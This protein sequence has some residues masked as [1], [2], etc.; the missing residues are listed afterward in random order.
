[1]QEVAILN[2]PFFNWVLLPFLIFI[3]RIIDVSI[4]T[5][6]LMLMARGRKIMA[7]ILGFFEVFIWI[8]AVRQI[9]NNLNNMA[10]YI[11]FP[12]GF[13]VGNYVGMI[14]EEKLAMG[15]VVIRIITKKEGTGLFNILK[16]KG[17]GVT[18][19]EGQGAT[20]K[21]DVIFSIVDRHHQEE[22]IKLIHQFNP[23]AFYS[24]EDIRS[25]REG[26]FPFRKKILNSH[27]AEGK[28]V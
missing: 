21:V 10:C 19:I 13:A 4:G 16:S 26:V 7:P 14:I 20:G 11:A 5:V 2:S 6:R 12:L 18:I 28:S 9:M 25:V 1:M 22:L 27:E 23:K 24:I 8:L 3:A 17:Y 15:Q